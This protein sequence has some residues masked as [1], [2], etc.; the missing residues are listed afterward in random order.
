MAKALPGAV[1]LGCSSGGL[2]G[3]KTVFSG[4]S[5]RLP[6][7]LLVVSHT[8]SEDMDGLCQLLAEQS[9]LPVR[10]ARERELPQPG[11]IYL[12]PG[13]YHLHVE[14]DGR[15]ALS[16]DPRDCY[17]RPSV[18]VLFESAAWCYGPRLAAV[19]LTGANNDGA[20]G[21]RAVRRHGGRAIVQDPADAHAPEMPRAAL[22][23]AGAD[24]VVP[25]ARIADTINELCL[26]PP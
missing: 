6:L 10:E 4:L 14:R 12:A 5:A 24:H 21:L 2:V 13:G 15:L 16:I 19:V 26:S 23:V 11:E 17:C 3:L 7:P 1:V 8:S 22:E 25:L 9:R 20:T 18:N